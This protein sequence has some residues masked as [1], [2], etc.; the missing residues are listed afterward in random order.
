MTPIHSV[1]NT[2][3]YRWTVV[4][5]SIDEIFGIAC[6]IYLYY[7]SYFNEPVS[8]ATLGEKVKRFTT[9]KIRLDYIQ[10]DFPVDMD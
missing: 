8:L 10:E 6:P 1:V 2:D 9:M 7:T 5:G 3:S 4:L